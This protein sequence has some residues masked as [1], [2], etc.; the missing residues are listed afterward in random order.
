M[1]NDGVGAFAALPR[2]QV[3]PRAFSVC[4]AD[5]ND[6][7]VA[8]LVGGILQ[9]ATINTPSF[10]AAAVLNGVGDGT[11]GPPSF[12]A[13]SVGGPWDI[14]AADVN[15]DG[16][17]DIASAQASNNLVEILLNEGCGLAPSPRPGD[18]NGDGIVNFSDITSV[19]TN[20]GATYPVNGP[21]DSNHD[22][23]VNFSDIT[24]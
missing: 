21:G 12:H 9:G 14:T 7:M 2:I 24:A 4:A 15:G 6:D 10:H 8:D 22:A 11:F 19:L 17:A 16:R 23:A 18:A 13:R 1:L 5:V 3:E 20:W